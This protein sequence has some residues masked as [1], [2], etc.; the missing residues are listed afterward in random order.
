MEWLEEGTQPNLATEGWSVERLE[1]EFGMNV[2]AALLTIEAI[3]KPQ[4]GQV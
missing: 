3:H 4:I 1:A 2:I